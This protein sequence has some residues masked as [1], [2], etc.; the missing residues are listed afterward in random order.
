VIGGGPI[1]MEMAQAH[2]RLGAEVTVIEGARA[3]GKD[4]PELAAIVLDNIRAEGVIIHEGSK[5][6][7]VERRGKTGVRVNYETEAG[8]LR[9]RLR[10]SGCRWPPRQCRRTG[11]GC[12]RRRA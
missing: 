10:P 4:D 2:R 12:R 7:S 8:R 3:L 11:S 6:T 9:R 1:G 5:V